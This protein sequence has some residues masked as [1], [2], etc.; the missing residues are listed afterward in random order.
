M[1]LAIPLIALGGLY[2]VSKQQRSENELDMTEGFETTLPNT[3]IPNKNYPSEYPIVDSE[4]TQTESLTVNNHY[5]GSTYTD[6]Y[7][8]PENRN[9]KHIL[10]NLDN[11][12]DRKSERT[13]PEISQRNPND[14][15]LEYTSLS[16][17]KVN[18]SYFSH[19]N[20]TPFFGATNKARDVNNSHQNES[21]LDTYLGKGSQQIEKREQA[22]LFAPNDNY[23]WAYGTP[24]QTE[25]MLSRVNP[26]SKISN[27]LPFEQEKVA[28]GI[29]LGAGTEGS[30]GYNSG[31]MNRET[32]LPKT[33]DELRVKTNAKASGVGLFGH[34]GP[35]ASNIKQMGTIGKLEKHGP[36][37]TFEMGHDRVMTTTGV[38]KG[39]TLRP[40]QEDRYTNRPETTTSY[41]GAAGSDNQGV[42]VDGEYM[43]SKHVDLGE[44]P[45]SV[46][47]AVG[48]SGARDGDYGSKTQVLYNN[49]RTANHQ[50]DYFGVVGGAIGSVISPLLDVL[51]PSRKENT[52]GTLRP[53]QNAASHVT[54]SY[55]FN[56]ADRPAHTLRETTENSKFHLNSTTNETNKGGYSV[57][58]VQPVANNRMN[59]SDYYYAGNASAANGTQEARPYD[60]EYR[61][62][63]NDIKSSTIDGR[64][65][66]GGMSLMNNNT[67]Y[68]T[69]DITQNL[70]VNR[71]NAPMY[72]RQPPSA[73]T[74]GQIQ[75]KQYLPSEME[76]KRN[77]SEILASLKKN[78][79][80]LSITS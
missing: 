62:R 79:Y 52:I 37:R 44:V 5:N 14:P 15:S 63:N 58:N 7:F 75:G 26:S 30:S 78:P 18:N 13:V 24:N 68:N 76:N 51:R 67:N 69:K 57:T 42:F 77:Q 56:P 10:G 33:V 53:Y 74:M 19:N 66:K 27:V 65:V 60:A 21:I 73:D 41:I 38:E 43:P 34:E 25:F 23:Q 2:V 49:N 3:D 70:E 20:M 72:S 16:G 11:N 71:Q 39:V 47:N 6:N 54:Q 4:L 31:M 45:L 80:A 29:G 22:P 55:V 28:P 35:A 32:W 61:Q 40:I 17:E 1:E 8:K 59:Q 36:E 50:D 12:I 46:A 48:R 64:L 9:G